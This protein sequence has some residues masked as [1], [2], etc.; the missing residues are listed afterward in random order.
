MLPF[1]QHNMSRYVADSS[2]TGAECGDED[3]CN[4]DEEIL[5]FLEEVVIYTFQQ[6]VYHLTK[7]GHRC[8]LPPIA[9]IL[10][11]ILTFL[12]MFGDVR[13]LVN[14]SLILKKV[15]DLIW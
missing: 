5:M 12:T 14:V 2:Q 4:A 1:L 13:N 7:V 11:V 9:L 15:F 6:T 8:N 3:L 10:F